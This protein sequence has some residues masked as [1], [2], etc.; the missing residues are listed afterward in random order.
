[1]KKLLLLISIAITFQ[2]QTQQFYKSLYGFNLGQY[3]EVA[4]NELGKPA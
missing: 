3:R 2:S 4:K 1:M